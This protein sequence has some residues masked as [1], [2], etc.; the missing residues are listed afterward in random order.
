MGMDNLTKVKISENKLGL[1]HNYRVK[2]AINWFK[3]ISELTN[4]ESE[5]FRYV[6]PA[7]LNTLD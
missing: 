6:N 1:L 4:N 7:T 2:L 3:K 5:V